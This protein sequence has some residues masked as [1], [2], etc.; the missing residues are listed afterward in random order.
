MTQGCD[1][2]VVLCSDGS[3]SCVRGVLDDGQTCDKHEGAHAHSLDEAAFSDARDR[4]FLASCQAIGY[5]PSRVHFAPKRAVD[6]CLSV[7]RAQEIIQWFLAVY[8]DAEVCTISP[9]VGNSQH[10]DHRCLGQAALDLYRK[11]AIRKL[12]LFVEPYCVG[13]FRQN[14]PEINL[15]RV[16]ADAGKEAACLSNAISQYCLWAPDQGR[17]AV[18]YHS[19]T[20]EFDSFVRG[21]ASFWH[22]AEEAR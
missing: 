17:F 6:G 5:R 15:E 10:S 9:L 1:V 19:V 18:G 3:K 22:S 13:A 8:P 12:N 14:N 4:E 20:G 2:H 21:P 16:A 7:D 11:G